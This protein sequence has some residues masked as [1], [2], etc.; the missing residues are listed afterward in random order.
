[1]YIN[2]TAAT[3]PAA[4]IA[5][6]TA[7]AD[8]P[9]HLIAGGADKK[10]D[11]SA[12]AETIAGS[13]KSVTLIEGTATPILAE[14][15]HSANPQLDLPVVRSMDAALIVASGQAHEGDIVL[16]SPGCASFG[17]FRDEFDRGQQFREGVY[18]RMN[19]DAVQ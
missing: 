9:I 18:A 4:A 6:L 8:R 3:A 19:T 14:L 11:M 2:D 1:L 15:I 7:F 10:L 17:V 12:L 16:L 5:S 13:A